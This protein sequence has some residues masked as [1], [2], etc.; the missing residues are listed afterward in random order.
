MYLYFMY[1]Y[2]MEKVSKEIITFKRF[3]PILWYII[4][5]EGWLYEWEEKCS[6]LIQEKENREKDNK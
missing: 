5:V 3:C 6:E 4:E 1:Y 2:I